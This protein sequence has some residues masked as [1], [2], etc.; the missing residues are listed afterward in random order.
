M[1]RTTVGLI[2]GLMLGAPAL[3]QE[4]TPPPVS[5]EEPPG[6]PP[7]EPSIPGQELREI[8]SPLPRGPQEAPTEGTGGSGQQQPATESDTEGQRGET[9]QLAGR[10]LGSSPGILYVEGDQGAA[11]PLRVT[12][13]TR[14]G[15][16]RIPRDQAIGTY[17]RK[18]LSPGK[19]VRVTF[20]VRTHEDGRLENVATT[21]HVQ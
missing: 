9:K 13:A 12:H 3:A 15:D 4:Q 8:P 2:A 10:V 7:E 19:S 20:D 11:I 6:A 17:L 1:K 18:E 16:R 5:G 14:L 21:L